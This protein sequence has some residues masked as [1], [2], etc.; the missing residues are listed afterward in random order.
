MRF[1][2]FCLLF[3]CVWF[4]AISQ[5]QPPE[6]TAVSYSGDI[7]KVTALDFE[8]KV[9]KQA[10][11]AIQLESLLKSWYRQNPRPVFRVTMVGSDGKKMTYIQHSQLGSSL[12]NK[13]ITRTGENP[14]LADLTCAFSD[15]LILLDTLR[16]TPSGVLSSDQF[17]IR[18]GPAVYT[19]KR[20][21]QQELLVTSQELPAGHYIP[22]T[23]E[24]LSGDVV[25]GTWTCWLYVLTDIERKALIDLTKGVYSKNTDSC[26]DIV[27][28]LVTLVRMTRGGKTCSQTSNYEAALQLSIRRFIRSHTPFC[29]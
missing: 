11:S 20:N 4:P 2:Y 16:I 19:L 7:D 28:E 1:R 18:T 24:R 29:Q 6:F 27:Q 5:T 22:S 17:R 23:V 15:T 21:A 9:L 10:R 26:K 8:S 12:N 25:K 13:A 14:Q 3:I